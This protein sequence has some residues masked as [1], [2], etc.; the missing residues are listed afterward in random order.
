MPK[1]IKI[2]IVTIGGNEF[3][4]EAL[5][6]INT[7]DMLKELVLSLGLGFI[8]AAGRPIVWCFDDK[9]TGKTLELS[10]TLEENEVGEGHQL[11][12][13]RATYAGCFLELAGALLPSGDY[14]PLGSLKPA[15]ASW[16]LTR[17]RPVTR[18][19]PA[20]FPRR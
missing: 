3:E 6:N 15:T 2:N 16:L 19:R 7:E 5:T 4:V 14:A 13:H 9:N 1:D 17:K 8:D 12:I 11:I 20:M 10:K 18:K